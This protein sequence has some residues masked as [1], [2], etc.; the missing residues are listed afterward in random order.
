MCPI[1][2]VTVD[3]EQRISFCNPAF[4][5]LFYYRIEEALGNDLTMLLAIAGSAAM[6]SAVHFL[7]RAETVRATLSARRKDQT[8]VEV[9]FYGVPDMNDGTYGGY[10]GVFLDVTER[11]RTEHAVSV[12]E[13]K[14]SKALGASPATIALSTAKD[15]RLIDVNETWVRVTGYSRDE[16][17]G[18]TPVEL[19][20]V[21]AEEFQRIGGQLAAQGGRVRN[22]ECRLRM[23]DGRLVIGSLSADEFDVNGQ[24]LRIVAVADMTA[25]RHAE[26]TLSR[27][28]QALIDTQEKER[29]R[30]SNALHNDVGQR[31]AAWQMAID[32]LG[33]DHHRPSIHE[34][35]DGLAELRKQASDIATAVRE[36]SRELHAPSLSLLSVDKVLSELCADAAK[37]LDMS[38]DFSSRRVPRV[39]GPETSVCLFRVL[40]EGLTNAATHSGTRRMRV[41]L[42]GTPGAIHLRIRDFGRGFP[43]E[44]IASGTGQGLGLI[45][46]RERVALVNGTLSIVSK[47]QRGTRIDVTLPVLP[48]DEATRRLP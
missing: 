37:R 45:T 31:L 46:M 12:S 42:R 26:D 20:L 3:P 38:V 28:S 6:A 21:S 33:R 16:A 15:D 7:S 44:T 43:V 1:A 29:L 19:G 35:V 23:R 17:I 48:A 9:D 41:T 18:R 22:V 30:V 36:L 40:Q 32:R 47:P 39:V 2:I 4:E 8:V 25:L 14:F 5:R 27:V 13:T 11:H 24:S 34:L 10:C